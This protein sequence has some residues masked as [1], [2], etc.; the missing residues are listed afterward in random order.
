MIVIILLVSKIERN[1][2]KINNFYISTDKINK[3]YKLVFICDFHNKLYKNNNSN[4]ID[5]IIKLNA[6]Y[7]ILGG[8]FIVFSNFFNKKGKIEIDNGKEFISNLC[9]KTFENS[10]NNN[11]NLK[12]IFFS[13]GNHELRLKHKNFIKEFNDFKEFLLYNDIII[14]DNE[15]YEIDENATISGLSLYDGY[16]NKKFSKKKNFQHINN[17]ILDKHFNISNNKFNIISF[18]KPDYIEDLCEYGFDL[19]LS[20]HNHGGLINFPIIGSIFS[21]DFALFPKY[22]KG[23]YK[24]LNKYAIVS[25]GLG[26]HFIK[27]RINNRPEICVININNEYNNL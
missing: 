10:K 11:Y 1:N 20:G 18:H 24:Y 27:I 16:Y 26:E 9:K 15:T 14:L 17:C 2:Y 7:I 5:D 23:I 8:D 6:D 12:R 19:I 3:N 22:N 4:L 13:F 21:P 25:S